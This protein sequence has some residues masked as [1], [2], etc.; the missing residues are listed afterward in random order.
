[1]QTNWD[2]G[3][4]SLLLSWFVNE[5]D[6]VVVAVLVKDAEV[7]VAETQDIVVVEV[8]EVEHDMTLVPVSKIAEFVP[9]A[10]WW[11]YPVLEPWKNVAGS[12]GLAGVV[13]TEDELENGSSGSGA[14]VDSTKNGGRRGKMV[15]V[16][17]AAVRAPTSSEAVARRGLLMARLESLLAT[18]ASTMTATCC[19]LAP[20]F[21]PDPCRP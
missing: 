10:L 20:T 9:F 13:P 8:L 21:P 1:M 15:V 2:L 18:C 16:L 17:E 6:V 4:R 5:L 11:S 19:T 7:G 12:A 14:R 3:F